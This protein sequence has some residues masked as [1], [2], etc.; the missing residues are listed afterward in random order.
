MQNKPS[1]WILSG[2][3][4][5]DTAQMQ[6]LAD[7]LGW[8]YDAKRLVYRA[9]ELLSN[10]FLGVTLAGVDRRQSSSLQPPWPDLVITAGRRNEPVARW[11]KR[12]SLGHTRLVHLGRPWSPVRCFD[13]VVT[14]PQYF[15]PP[16][17]NVLEVDLPLHG[18]TKARLADW[19][20][21]WQSSFA[22]LSRPLWAVLL[23]GDS[24]PF[25][26]TR[27]KA[28]RL[29]NWL[30]DKLSETGGTVVVSNS[31]RTPAAVYQAFLE[32]L[33]VPVRA[34]HWRAGDDNNP[35]PGYL[36][37]ADYLVVTGESMSM[38]AEA[39]ETGKPLYIF[40]MSDCPLV[41]SGDCRPWWQIAH[42]YRYKPLTHRLAMR[43]APLRMKRDIS[44]IQQR[45]VENGQAVWVGDDVAIKPRP[46]H[47]S[48][49]DRAVKR[50]RS[51]LAQDDP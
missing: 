26:F 8:G 7:A 21:V 33:V 13:L 43:F 50:V 40:D 15:V 10:R 28:V 31:A 36:A 51:M 3:K 49:L 29:A 47:F 2:F 22:D 48:S 11:I 44:R 20:Q 25:V 46:V 30:N 17:G 45:L 34:H 32:T 35:Y 37:C 38:L 18:V 42:N 1:V 19:K 14:T 5:G 12:Q 16:A 4:A 27:Q 9:T 41:G 39:V 6:A 23:G 24:G